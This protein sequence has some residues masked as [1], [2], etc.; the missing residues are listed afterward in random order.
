M[1][2]IDEAKE[3][4]AKHE[5]KQYNELSELRSQAERARHFLETTEARMIELE[6]RQDW[7]TMFESKKQR[8]L[9]GAFQ[10]LR[11]AIAQAESS[12]GKKVSEC[13]SEEP[14]EH[15]WQDTSGVIRCEIGADTKDTDEEQRAGDCDFSR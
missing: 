14:C 2:H 4:T 5:K 10:G 11:Q 3:L 8:D 6:M 13:S 15:R 7:R 1:S 9:K 12:T